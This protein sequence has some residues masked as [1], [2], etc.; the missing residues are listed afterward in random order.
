MT[1]IKSSN[2]DAD[3]VTGLTEDTSPA[4][5]DVIITYDTSAG[6]LKKVQKSNFALSA[7]EI[8]NISP[9]IVDPDGSTTTNI[10]INGVGFVN[11]PVVKFVGSDATVFT[12]PS[13]TFNSSAQIVAAT[14]ATMT[15]AKSPYDI[16]IENGNN[17]TVTSLDLL[18]LDNTPFFQTAA[19]TNL[20][21]VASGD[22]DFSGLTTAAAVDPDSDTITHTISAGSI[23]TG[24]SLNTN[25]TFTGT[26]GSLSNQVFTFTVQAATTNYT[27]TRQFTITLQNE[28][29][30]G[31]TGGTIT[32]SG[33]YNIHRFTGACC[34]TVT[35]LGNGDTIPTGGPNVVDY[36][37]VAGGGGGGGGGDA[38]PGG[39][40]GGGGYR[41]SGGAT[42]YCAPG[43]G[44]GVAGITVT[45][46][47][48]P[49][50]IGG[51]GGGAGGGGNG[52]QGGTSSFSSISSAGG[53]GF[54]G[55]GPYNGQPG[56]SGGGG[57]G[58]Y[59]GHSGGS[60]NSPPVSPPQGTN[61]GPGPHGGQGG[62][63][64][65]ANQSGNSGDGGEG[66]YNTISGSPVGYSG[67]GGGGHGGGVPG[68]WGEGTPSQS[69]AANRGGGGGQYAGGG[70]GV[71]IIRYKAR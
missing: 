5:D 20:G 15:A 65:G 17:L 47:T 40:G 14:D 18:I 4:A 10:T 44:T 23:P 50:G 49:I 68:A 19:D 6:S 48:Y 25:G 3:V 27:I 67:G 9:T 57:R 28:K 60:G 1:K 53:G 42:G 45:T 38:D 34:F 61:G 46:T 29:F 16:K 21:N 70:S 8:S 52:S 26:V 63:G 59:S 43:K 12:S 62:G 22:T 11:P 30:I 35:A 33:D 37:V 66:D 55:G 36:L 13:V 54:T 7:P 58:A 41:T 24:M 31:A 32:E 71:V 64:G 69:G 56:G 51:G 2:L 39:G